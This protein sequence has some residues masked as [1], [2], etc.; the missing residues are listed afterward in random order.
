[1]LS[2]KLSKEIKIRIK[3]KKEAS[4]EKNLIFKFISEIKKKIK[5]EVKKINKPVL[6]VVCKIIKKIKIKKENFL[7]LNF[8]NKKGKEKIKIFDTYE[9]NIFSSPKT[10]DK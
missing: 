3:I 9:P 1:M 7:I 10:P 5:L 8:S 4:I 2:F 6:S